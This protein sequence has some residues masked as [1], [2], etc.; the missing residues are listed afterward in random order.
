MID[1]GLCIVHFT[2]Y[3]PPMAGLENSE[4]KNKTLTFEGREGERGKARLASNECRSGGGGSQNGSK[5]CAR[6]SSS[7]QLAFSDPLKTSS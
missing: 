2:L 1:S 5:A 4:A 3:V 7:S 6:H